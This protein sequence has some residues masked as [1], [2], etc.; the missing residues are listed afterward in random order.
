[1]AALALARPAIA[2]TSRTD[3]AAV[4]LLERAAATYQSSR[5]VRAEFTQTLTNPRTAAV[6][7]SSGEFFQRGA[8]HFAFRFTDPPDD[9]IVAD[10]AVIWLYLPS[11]AKG[12]VLKVPRAAG[13]G[14]DLAAS[15][16]REPARRYTVTAAP[17]T[18]IDGRTVRVVRLVPRTADAVFTR[19]TVWL[20]PTTA[21]VRRAVFVEA[22]GLVR[23]LHFSRLRTGTRLPR[24]VFTFVPPAGVRVIDQAVLL[25][26]S[27]PRP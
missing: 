4:A 10:G 17:D 8:Q 13:A 19:A 1:M 20:D 22:T 14:M 23:T 18:T 15:L 25:G 5:T 11:T 16:L 3:S 7:R 9:R 26:G 24:G 27:V 2:Q 12:Q 21:L 6:F